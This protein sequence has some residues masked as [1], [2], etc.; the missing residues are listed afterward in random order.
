VLQLRELAGRDTQVVCL[1]ATLPPSKQDVFLEKMDMRVDGSKVL[2]DST[3]RPNIAY[4]I[5]EYDAEDE[6]EFLRELVEQKKAQYPPSD[7]IVIFCRTIEKVKQFARDLQCTAFWR[8]VGT[9]Q[10]KAE[11]VE[12]L[13]SSEERVFT[14]T[15]ALGEGID[16]PGIRVVMHVGVIDS[17][18]D[19][20]QQSGRAGRDG[21]TPSE[22][23]ILRK[24]QIGRDGQ[25]RPERGWKV[26][27]QMTEFLGG[28]RCQQVV[29]DRY[30][31]GSTD[32]ATCR[33]GEQSCNVCRGRGRKRSRVVHAA[34][35][36]AAKRGRVEHEDDVEIVEHEE[37]GEGTE[38]AC[39]AAQASRDRF[40]QERGQYSII[41][42][43]Q[44]KERI[45]QGRVVEQ[46]DAL[47]REWRHGCSV[48]RIRGRPSN[49]GHHWRVCPH[50]VV[51]VAVIE[52]VKR[53][54]C[55]VRWA[56]A[57]MCCPQCWA[58]QAICHSYQPIDN[59]GR[60][61][62]R[63]GKPGCQYRGVLLEAVAVSLAARPDAE[64][65]VE[66]VHK[67]G[68]RAMLGVEQTSDD[69]DDMVD[70]W[71]GSSVMRGSVEISGMCDLF[72]LWARKEVETE[73]AP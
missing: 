6:V 19:Y 38:E 66:W 62:Y 35:G 71:M 50:E 41:A 14:C 72:W 48:C 25:R 26:E 64:R 12:M 28:D 46:M 49:Q 5:E 67:E 3:V 16:A 59:T 51:D 43:Q 11:I 13:A 37:G 36:R 53:T 63:K 58:P 69:R 21:H 44:R 34:E 10:E 32:R 33:P 7:K 9:E 73:E 56:T 42:S 52:E 65:I 68:N 20:N 57:S 2:R 39:P 31:D 24:V 22:A 61:R 30:M 45:E 29:M 1:T 15:N 23:I 47:F 4:R 55:R 54:L 18:D 70:A 17:L 60:M 40:E 27:P 8:T